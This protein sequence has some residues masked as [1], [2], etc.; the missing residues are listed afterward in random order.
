MNTFFRVCVFFCIM[1][2]VFNLTWNFI[3]SLQAFQTTET[4]EFEKDPHS[5]FKMLTSVGGMA[6]VLAIISVGAVTT[7]ITRSPVFIGITLF[8]LVF[9]SC[10]LSTLNIIRIGNYLPVEFELI[11]TTGVL[12]I[13]V[14]AVIGM[15][16]GS[17]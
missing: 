7:F 13:F 2:I 14:G 12:F 1:L 8:G 10:Y 9:W 17:G 16:S 4:M 15:L 6:G 3:Y 11:I 5:I